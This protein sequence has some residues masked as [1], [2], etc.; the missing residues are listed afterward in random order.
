M[1]YEI[2]YC[3]AD[4]FFLQFSMV[5]DSDWKAPIAV[6]M[7]S[8]GMA[9]GIFFGFVADR[10]DTYYAMNRARIVKINALTYEPDSHNSSTL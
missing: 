5:C 7:Y 2:K 10:C 4:I 6:S 8:L 3:A 1:S 9:L